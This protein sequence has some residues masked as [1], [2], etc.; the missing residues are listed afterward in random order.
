MSRLLLI[1]LIAMGG[2]P[3]AARAAPLW[4]GPTFCRAEAT[5]R[6]RYAGKMV[7]EGA[8]LCFDAGRSALVSKSCE[9]GNCRALSDEICRIARAPGSI[10][11]E[12]PEICAALGALSQDGAFF[13]GEKWWSTSR[14]YFAQDR[15]FVDLGVLAARRAQCFKK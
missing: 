5:F 2:L 14:C 3:L 11:F 4:D 15:S 9:A 8:A 6:Y 10:S 7:E 1:L 13:D 12:G